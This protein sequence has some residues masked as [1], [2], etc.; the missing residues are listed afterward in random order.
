MRLIAFCF[1]L[2]AFGCGGFTQSLFQLFDEGGKRGSKRHQDRPQL[3]HVQPNFAPFELGDLALSFFDP[4]RQLNLCN[5]RLLSRFAQQ[6]EECGVLGG[7]DGLVHAAR[8]AVK[9]RAR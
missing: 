8:L 3:D 7:V 4:F 9:P 1:R 6:R 5:A 2:L